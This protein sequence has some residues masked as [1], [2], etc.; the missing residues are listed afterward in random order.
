MRM[1][2]ADHDGAEF[3]ICSSNA[4]MSC[5]TNLFAEQFAPDRCRFRTTQSLRTGKI[6]SVAIVFVRSQNDCRCSAKGRQKTTDLLRYLLTTVTSELPVRTKPC[7][8]CY[9]VYRHKRRNCPLEERM[10]LELR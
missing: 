9:R 7:G 10:A 4:S 2:N 3:L 6:I 1:S 5:V 8:G